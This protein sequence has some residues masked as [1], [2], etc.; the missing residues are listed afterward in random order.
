MTTNTR[1]LVLAYHVRAIDAAATRMQSGTWCERWK[2]QRV[3]EEHQAAIRLLDRE[4]QMEDR[5]N[6]LTLTKR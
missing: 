6:L 2:M 3:I 4:C 1:Q 5:T